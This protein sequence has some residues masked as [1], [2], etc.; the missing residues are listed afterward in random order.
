MIH[1]HAEVW[2]AGRPLEFPLVFRPLLPLLLL[3][4]GAL[5]AQEAPAVLEFG[6]QERVR[7]ESWDNL[8]D[9]REATPDFRTQYR[10]RT[11]LWAV[12]PLGSDISFSVGV[13]NEDRKLT[14]PDQAVNGRE[15]AFETFYLDWRMGA[16]WSLRAG[17]QNLM[18][19]DGFVLWDGGALDG[20]RAAYV[21]ALDLAW[22]AGS[23]RLEFLAISDPAKDRYL[24]RLNE[25]DN[26]RERQL[27]NEHDEAALGMYA[28]W[29][30]EGRDVQA[31]GFHK[32]ERHDIR[33]VTDPL[34]VADRR[35]E[36][37]GARWVEALSPGLAATGEFAVQSGRQEGRPGTA[38]PS[39][40][41]RAWGGQANLTQTFQSSSRPEVRLGWVGLSGDDPATS[42]HEGWDPLFSRWPKW[43]EL[44]VYSLVPE[45]GVA[46]WSNLNLWEATVQAH[47]NDRLGLRGSL[48]WLSAFH[49]A[50]VPGPIFAS[51]LGRGRLLELRADLKLSECWQGHVLYERLNPGSFYAG[52]DAGRFFRVEAIYTFQKRR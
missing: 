42:A 30:Q 22:V 13:V 20:S 6:F 12:V 37:L 51:G 29:K 34:F 48:Y 43:S 3:V 25:A 8:S 41:I 10:F 33:A 40:A 27:L 49:H 44:Y 11:R 16:G 9:H 7:S 1:V 15:V 28:T 47:P 31:Y 45:A 14:H 23:S 5:L 26:P 46:T 52:P 36:T 50:T 38:E 17:R 32:T 4:A 2:D 39:S 18:R 21:N 35:V 19:G 24:P